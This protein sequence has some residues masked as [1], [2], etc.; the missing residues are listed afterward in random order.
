[1][2]RFRRSERGSIT[3]FIAI[4]A[5]ALLFLGALVIDGSRQLSAR[6]RAVAYAEEAARAAAQKIDLTKGWVEI[7]RTEAEGAMNEYCSA[8]QEAD[9]EMGGCELTGFVEAT[10]GGQI[11]TVTVEVEV[12]YD[13]IML[14]MIPGFASSYSVTGE[15]TAHP[16]EGIL[17]PEFD[18]FTP[19][20]PVVDTDPVDPGIPQ[21]SDVPTGGTVPT[22]TPTP[23]CRTHGSPPPPRRP[24]CPEPPTDTQT[25][26]TDTQ[27]PPD[28]DDPDGPGGPGG[29][30]DGPGDTGP[31]DGPGH[32]G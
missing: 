30:G 14:D 4:V 7:L 29:P 26:P 21:G 10:R 25:P 20:T 27:T 6:A 16:I 11:A 12:T 18:A 32:G 8:A 9:T 15:A 23:T 2:S 22:P 24:W 13:P 28:D 31:G 1:M 3:P 5:L 17:E 19:P